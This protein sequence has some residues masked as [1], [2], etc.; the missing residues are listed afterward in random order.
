M[1]LIT[2]SRKPSC[3]TRRFCKGLEAVLPL[4][5]YVSRGR[6]PIRL[7]SERARVDGYYRAFVVGETKGN[8]SLIRIL[9]L[10]ARPFEWMGQLYISGAT[11]QSSERRRRL[12]E[13]D[14]VVDF[15]RW[16]I[17]RDIF[18]VY[19]GEEGCVLEER[20]GVVR[21][22]HGNQEVGLRFR[23]RGWDPVPKKLGFGSK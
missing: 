8:P 10:R 19:E 1:I 13:D 15:D 2:S 18:D 5:R 7:L 14:L 9:D 23:I 6:A 22:L 20:A 17:L 4:S 21:F 11:L 12:E 16:G 3:Q